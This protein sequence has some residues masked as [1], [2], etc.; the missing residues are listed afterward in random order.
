MFAPS[1]HYGRRPLNDDEDGAVSGRCWEVAIRLRQSALGSARPVH[2]R[3]TA[4]LPV[5]EA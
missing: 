3:V 4:H 1:F 2:F 5:R